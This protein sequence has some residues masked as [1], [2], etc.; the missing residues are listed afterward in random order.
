[1]SRRRSVGNL[2]VSGISPKAEY[3]EKRIEDLKT[4]GLKLNVDETQELISLLQQAVANPKWD[5]LNITGYRNNN[6]LTV[7]FYEPV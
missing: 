4:V 2:K 6:N 5:Y 3:R 1:M 7:T